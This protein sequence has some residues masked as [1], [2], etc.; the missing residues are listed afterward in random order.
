[1]FPGLF[2]YFEPDCAMPFC[3]IQQQHEQRKL[4]KLF[5]AELPYCERSTFTTVKL[6]N[7]NRFS[8]DRKVAT[9][10]EKGNDQQWK[11]FFFTNFFA[12]ISKFFLRLQASMGISTIFLQT[13]NQRNYTK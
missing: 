7:S 10:N 12:Q 5:F 11:M 4:S 6:F 9:N 2:Y 13:I 8:L 3:S 1:M